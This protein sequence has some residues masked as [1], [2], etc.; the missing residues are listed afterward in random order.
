MYPLSHGLLRQLRWTLYWDMRRLVT[1]RVK[2]GRG[3]SHGRLIRIS[4]HVG[5]RDVS[6]TTMVI[7][8]GVVSV[9]GSPKSVG[10]LKTLSC[11]L[12]V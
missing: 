6:W 3:S 5:V 9:A 1:A 7:W 10:A 4:V 12:C 2:L 11:S 8:D